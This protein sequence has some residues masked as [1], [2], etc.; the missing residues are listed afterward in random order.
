MILQSGLWLWNQN[1]HE[2]TLKKDLL[3]TQGTL[4]SVVITYKGKELLKEYKHTHTLN[5]FDIHLKLTQPCKST[6]LQFKNKTKKNP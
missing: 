6:I 2:K 4:L 5:H 1:P 3:Y